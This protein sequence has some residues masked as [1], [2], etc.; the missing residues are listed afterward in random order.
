MMRGGAV[1]LAVLAV[2]PVAVWAADLP[3]ADLATGIEAIRQG[4]TADAA[5]IFHGLAKAGD[6]D[7]QFNLALLYFDGRGVPQNSREALYWAWRARLSGIANAPALIAKLTD[8][9][10][11]NL[12]QELVTRIEADLEPRIQQGEG[13]AMME[14]SYLYSDLLAEPDLALAYVW[15]A[16]AAALDTPNAVLAR[17]AALQKIAPA[18]RLAAQDQA[19]ETLKGLCAAGMAGQAICLAQF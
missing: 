5:V 13:R 3:Q 17:D 19:I 9:A 14:K 4:K 2:L 6:G 8:A 11:P 10:T 12:R 16:L 18:D 1:I 7:A 15:L